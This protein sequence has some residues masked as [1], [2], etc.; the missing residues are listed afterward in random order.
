MAVVNWSSILSK[1]E[2]GMKAPE[3]KKEMQDIV[4]RRVIGGFGGSGTNNVIRAANRFVE[5]LKECIDECAGSNFSNG[6]LGETAIDA[7][8][9]IS[10]G[11]AEE[12]G[13]RNC[14]SIPITFSMDDRHRDSLAPDVFSGVDDIVVLL[15][16]GYPR[17]GHEMGVVFGEWHGKQIQN[18]RDRQGAHFIESA[19]HKFMTS[20]ARKYGVTDIKV[21]VANYKGY[22]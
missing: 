3:K 4:D 12:Y 9:K 10:I 20:E 2:A 7:L 11:A 6:D 14:Y 17:D 22:Y 21:N 19:V 8:K 13:S 16:N 5:I 1:A 18:L 15:N